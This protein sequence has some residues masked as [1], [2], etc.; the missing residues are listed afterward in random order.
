M[1]LSLSTSETEA[2]TEISAVACRPSTTSTWVSR[3][4]WTAT[5]RVTVCMPESSYLTV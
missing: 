3:L 2:V 5:V 1:A 4:S